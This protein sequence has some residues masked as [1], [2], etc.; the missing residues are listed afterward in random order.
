[1]DSVPNAGLLPAEFLLPAGVDMQKWSIIA[2]D[3]FTSEPEYWSRVESLV[4][5]QPSALHTILPEI[6]LGKKDTDARIAKLKQ[7]MHSYLKQGLFVRHNGYVFIKRLLNSGIVRN[8]LLGMIDLEDYSYSSASVPIRSTEETVRERIPARIRIRKDAPLEFPHVILLY[9]DPENTVISLIENRTG[10]YELLYDFELMENG[11]HLSGWLV[12][13][14]DEPS[15]ADAFKALS[16]RSSMLFAVG[17]GNHSLAAAKA[18]YEELKKILPEEEYLVHPARYVLVEAVNLHDPAMEFEPIHRVVFDVSPEHL[19]LELNQFLFENRYTRKKGYPHVFRYIT[20]AGT[21]ELAVDRLRYRLQVAVLQK[22][23]DRYVKKHGGRIDYIHG[24][25]TIGFLA[26]K[27]DT[28]GFLLPHIKKES[29]F[30][31]V[32]ANGPFPRKTFSCGNAEDK[33]YYL[34]C[35]KIV[36]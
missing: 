9:D 11:G 13:R 36:P 14:D 10:G 29:L 2:C 27:P 19:L 32:A 7:T 5:N 28:V 18:C 34:E 12:D 15:V 16:E 30:A 26:S 17:D 20:S 22:F 24:D 21:G 8:G 23:L 35:R 3:Q 1:M 31:D 25:Q 6:H 4:G 33:R